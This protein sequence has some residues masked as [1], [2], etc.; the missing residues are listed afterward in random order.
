MPRREELEETS[1]G[2]G[3]KYLLAVMNSTVARDFLRA[4]RRS[5][6]HLYP[7]DWKKLPIPDIPTNEQAP[8]V[9]LVDRILDARR[10]DPSA[11]VSEWEREIDERIY[12]LYGLSKDEIRLVEE[13]TS[14]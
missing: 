2:F 11:D 7:E 9:R 4:H 12:R 6:I 10:S 1:R 13:S 5:N 14:R 8:I 3:V